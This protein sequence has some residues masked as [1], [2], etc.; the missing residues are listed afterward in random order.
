MGGSSE[1][2]GNMGSQ[3]YGWAKQNPDQLMNFG[4]GI[5]GIFN[6][7]LGAAARTVGGMSSAY[8]LPQ[9][10]EEWTNAKRAVEQQKSGATKTVSNAPDYDGPGTEQ[11]PIKATPQQQVLADQKAPTAAA[12]TEGTF[13]D[14]GGMAAQA[15]NAANERLKE[16]RAG[17]ST[18]VTSTQAVTPPGKTL[19]ATQGGGGGQ[20]SLA[21]LAKLLTA[22]RG[23][24]GGGGMR[25]GGFG[26]G[27]GGLGGQA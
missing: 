14:A 12:I 10:Q 19:L 13:K 24:G 20:P 17:R 21:M 8:M 9:R 2:V 3:A 15:R 25:P 11:V 26:T 5:L 18:P 7:T 27:F 1:T 6:P 22:S 23:S 16:F 4:S